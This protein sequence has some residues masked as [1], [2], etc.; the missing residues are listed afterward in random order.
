M[1]D[2]TDGLKDD[3]AFMRG[4]AEQGR[5]GPVLGGIFLA[6][7]G[8]IFGLACLVQWAMSRRLLPWGEENAPSLWWGTSALFVLVWLALMTRVRA[9]KS[10]PPAAANFAFSMAWTGC[11]FGIAAMAASIYLVSR[12]L[13]DPSVQFLWAPMAFAFYG[14]AW[15]VSAAMTRKPWMF[16]VAAVAYL[17]APLL[18]SFVGN[19]DSLLAMSAGLLLTLVVPGVRLTMTR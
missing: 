3:I 10:D 18:A 6:A 17:F 9:G 5:H 12:Q 19:I 11:A 16:A 13:H 8:L 2:H 7:A 15:L 4:L 1:S 14:T